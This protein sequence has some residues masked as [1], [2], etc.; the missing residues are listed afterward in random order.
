MWHFPLGV[1]FPLLFGA[2]RAV[3]PPLFYILK[4]FSSGFKLS[5]EVSLQENFDK[6]SVLAVGSL[7]TPTI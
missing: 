2:T 3:H 4:H 7:S 5:I 6:V 1:L